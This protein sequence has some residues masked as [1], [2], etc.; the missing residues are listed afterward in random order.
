MTLNTSKTTGDTII[1]AEWNEAA[2]SINKVTDQTLVRADISD[3]GSPIEN[4]SEDITPQLG[5][6]LDSQNNAISGA[7]TV[8]F[9]GIVDNA[10]TTIDFSTGQKQKKTVSAN[11]ILTLSGGVEG[12]D[13]KLLLIQDATGTRDI[14]F[15]NATFPEGVMDTSSDVAA[16]RRVLSIFYDGT[17][18]V[19]LET[20]AY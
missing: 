3:F 10:T 7:K 4:L 18:Y 14:T 11:D 8:T 17:N 5:G 15:T 2:T 13:Y 12:G 16:S 1:A 9:N 19:V 6:N 20:S